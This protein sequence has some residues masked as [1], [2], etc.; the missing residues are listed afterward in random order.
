[1]VGNEPI[2]PILI[3]SQTKIPRIWTHGKGK[4]KIV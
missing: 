2:K 4:L 3:K 1:V